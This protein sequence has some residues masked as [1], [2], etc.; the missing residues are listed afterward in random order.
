[1]QIEQIAQNLYKKHQGRYTIYEM[2]GHEVE[3]VYK[4]DKIKCK[5]T[6]VRRDVF[7]NRIFFSDDNGH[8]YDFREPSYIAR[9]DDGSVI[10][11]YVNSVE[12]TFVDETEENTPV[13]TSETIFKIL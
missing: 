13:E 4:G 11:S 1:M 5:L 2:E 7:G 9:G 10:F 12:K 3:F 8:T 6:S